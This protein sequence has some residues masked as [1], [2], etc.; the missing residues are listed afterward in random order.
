MVAI[1]FVLLIGIAFVGALILGAALVARAETR[2]AGLW[3][4]GGTLGLA[5]LVPLVWLLA[6]FDSGGG[7]AIVTNANGQQI[8]V[9]RGAT[10]DSPVVWLFAIPVGIGLLVGEILLLINPRTRMTGSALLGVGLLVA[11]FLVPTATMRRDSPQLSRAVPVPIFES[12]DAQ[13]IPVPI[14]AAHVK[15]AEQVSPPAAPDAAA[16][17]PTAE[18]GAAIETI[19]PPPA[20]LA[21]PPPENDVPTTVDLAGAKLTT[22]DKNS[23]PEWAKAGGGITA[24]G[25]YFAVV[26][27]GPYRQFNDCWHNL[28]PAVDQEARNYGSRHGSGYRNRWPNLRL[29]DDLHNQIIAE[30]YLERGDFS[31]GE[32]MT[33][34]TRLEFSDHTLAAVDAWQ[35]ELLAKNRTIFAGIF[36]GLI[37]ALL[38]ILYA[39]FRI[40][41]E[42]LGYYTWKLRVAAGVLMLVVVVAGFISVAIFFDEEWQLGG[43]VF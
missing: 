17:P 38:G 36:G 41:T 12:S 11:L 26:K 2:T 39:Y 15:G 33:L 27:S 29:P 37:V 6:S 42:T 10:P 4:L 7:T 40:D 21:A 24:D 16:T 18:T 35:A 34:Y 1:V 13:P 23:L 14:D 32:M 43:I 19:A 31:V 8:R 9:Q 3:I 20:T 22:G 5:V 30:H 25:T 28:R